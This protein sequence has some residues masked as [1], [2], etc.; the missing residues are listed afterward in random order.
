MLKI[1]CTQPF[2]LIFCSAV[3]SPIIFATTAKELLAFTLP[4]VPL[5]PNSIFD[6][7]Y[8]G[9]QFS[10]ST[11]VNNRL[12][13]FI[14]CGYDSIFPNCN[15]LCIN[16]PEYEI[17]DARPLLSPKLAPTLIVSESKLFA[18][19]LAGS[20]IWQESHRFTTTDIFGGLLD[21]SSKCWKWEALPPLPTLPPL[22]NLPCRQDS[23]VFSIL[24]FAVV[25][26]SSIFLSFGYLLGPYKE[27]EFSIT[28]DISREAWGNIS[29]PLPFYGEWS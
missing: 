5:N 2:L 29:T 4:P 27:R 11:L 3:R 10:I 9:T 19:A 25:F 28:Y 20:H 14:G 26:S 7:S 1:L 18:F 15:D 24:S 13:F 16:H 17:I 22:P 6:I 8:L 12:I 23:P 21:T